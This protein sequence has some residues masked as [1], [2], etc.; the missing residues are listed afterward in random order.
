M[1]RSLLLLAAV[2][3]LAFAA[4]PPPQ[5]P[6]SAADLERMQG[7]WV[8]IAE[9]ANEAAPSYRLEMTVRGNRLTYTNPGV[10]NPTWQIT[11]DAT[12]SPKSIYMLGGWDFRGREGFYSFEDD[13]LLMYLYFPGVRPPPFPCV[14]P[15][16]DRKIFK[17]VQSPRTR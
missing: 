14:S 12:T 9:G 10:P 1:R 17:R 3:G 4:A 13:T 15:L 16:L 5:G 6:S 8:L 2:L 7:D 11:L